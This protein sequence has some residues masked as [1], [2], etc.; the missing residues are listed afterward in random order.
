M[1]AF[2]GSIYVNDFNMFNRIYR[3]YI[4]AE[5][6]YRAYRDNLNLFFVRGSNGTMIPVTSLG[7]TDYTTGPG[8]IKRFNMFNS[9]TVTARRPTGTVRVRP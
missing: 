9:A 5:A 3:V 4:Q 6:P 1:K 2:T 8:T 7:T